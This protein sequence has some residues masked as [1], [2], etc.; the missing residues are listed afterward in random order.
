MILSE[1][2]LLL[3]MLLRNRKVFDSQEGEIGGVYAC[4]VTTM[5]NEIEQPCHLLFYT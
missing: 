4:R 3:W 5:T 1:A 2:A